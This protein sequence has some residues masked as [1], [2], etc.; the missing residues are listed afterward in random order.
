MQVHVLYHHLVWLSKSATK[1]AGSNSKTPYSS[2]QPQGAMLPLRCLEAI[3]SGFTASLLK[4]LPGLNDQAPGFPFKRHASM[5]LRSGPC[6]RLIKS[7][8]VLP[9]SMNVSLKAVCAR[10]TM[11]RRSPRWSGK[12]SVYAVITAVLKEHNGFVQALVW[13]G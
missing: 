6:P 4:G 8:V 10:D 5:Q 13:L 3:H 9:L 7:N 12:L 11:Q 2:L 1:L